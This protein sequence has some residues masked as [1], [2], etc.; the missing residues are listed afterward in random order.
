MKELHEITATDLLRNFY[1]ALNGQGGLK[2]NLTY[3]LQKNIMRFLN[4]KIEKT[5][6]SELLESLKESWEEKSWKWSIDL[7]VKLQIEEILGVNH[8]KNERTA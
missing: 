3:S 6:A 1:N 8:E 5:K 7:D 2:G 4:Q